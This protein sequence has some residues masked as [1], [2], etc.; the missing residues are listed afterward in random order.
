MSPAG[1]KRWFWKTYQDGKEGRLAL[2][3]YPA[4][5]LSDARQS[6]DAA[7]IVKAEGRNP[8]EVR[9][10]EKFKAA[11]PGGDTFKAVALEL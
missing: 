3:S 4:M 6:R 11:R 10:V 1:S 2:G 8:V 9:K 5:S 7:K